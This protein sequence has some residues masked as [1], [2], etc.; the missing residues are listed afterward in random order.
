[1]SSYQRFPPF[2][3]LRGDFGMISIFW[4]LSKFYPSSDK[5]FNIPYLIFKDG[6]PP[7]EKEPITMISKDTSCLSFGGGNF[8][9]DSVFASKYISS[10]SPK[11]WKYSKV[12][13]NQESSHTHMLQTYL[14]FTTE[15]FSIKSLKVVKKF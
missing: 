3:E 4:T 2:K 8:P 15:I 12:S 6:V 5:G 1:M 7:R 9:A 11:E 14:L 10:F 13:L